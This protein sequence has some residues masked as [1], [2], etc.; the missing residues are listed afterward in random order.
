MVGNTPLKVSAKFYNA[1]VQ[2]VF[3]YGNET[4]NLL[5]TTLARLEGFH[6][7]AA[8]RMAKKHKPKK[9]QHHEWV[10]PRSSNVLQECGM[11]TI[12]H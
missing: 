12:L 5:T 2:S 8:Y 3:L 11:A 6:I 10:Y 4:W 7:R 1:V 9:G